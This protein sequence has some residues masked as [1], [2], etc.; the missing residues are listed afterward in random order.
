M[1]G[2]V[3]PSQGEG[4]EL[5]SDPEGQIRESQL[6]AEA[7]SFSKAVHGRGGEWVWGWARQRPLPPC[8]CGLETVLEGISMGTSDAGQMESPFANLSGIQR[9]PLCCRVG[10]MGY[11]PPTEVAKMDGSGL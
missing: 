4:W 3:R 1:T 2:L 7:A 9:I 5:R 8:L 11:S 6:R 10:K